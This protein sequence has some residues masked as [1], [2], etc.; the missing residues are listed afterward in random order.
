[1]IKINEKE[2]TFTLED[3]ARLMNELV[4]ELD[5]E[6]DFD[7]TDEDKEFHDMIKMFLIMANTIIDKADFHPKTIFVNTM[8]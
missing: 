7:F 6:D 8:N 2:F 5:P 1:M 3:Y 4:D